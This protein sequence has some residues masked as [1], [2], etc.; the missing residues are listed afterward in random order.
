[1]FHWNN[2]S[3]S[4]WFPVIFLAIYFGRRERS[5]LKDVLCSFVV[6]FGVLAGLVFRNLVFLG[7]VAAITAGESLN[8]V[9]QTRRGRTLQYGML[10]LSLVILTKTGLDGYRMAST[11]HVDSRLGKHLAE[12]LDKIQDLTPPGAAVACYWAD[13]YMVQSYCMRPTLTDGLF[14]DKEIV[15]R[16]LDESKAY[17]SDNETPLWD[18]C[19]RHGAAYLLVSVQRAE[20]YAR[21]AGLTFD[22]YFPNTGPTEAG[23][24]TVL[25]RMLRMPDSLKHFHELFRNPGYILFQVVDAESRP[26]GPAS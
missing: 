23:K 22:T 4:A 2:L 26:K 18:Y 21:Q 12:A 6:L 24:A 17:Y 5:A 7:P 15:S 10:A 19:S 9:G 16:I 1:M 14:E 25:F 13:G 20:S 8:V 3:W 11:F